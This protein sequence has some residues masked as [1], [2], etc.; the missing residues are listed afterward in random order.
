MFEGQVDME[1]HVG[2]IVRRQL[3]LPG[4]RHAYHDSPSTT[5]EGPGS[6][7]PAVYRTQG[8]ICAVELQGHFEHT[9]TC[10]KGKLGITGCPLAVGRRHPVPV[11]MISQLWSIPEDRVKD[12]GESLPKP[13]WMQCDCAPYLSE[14]PSRYA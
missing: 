4:R 13:E 5:K 10:T 12:P 7:S 9:V 2:D 8:Q 1:V 11:T 6:V 3:R 14:L